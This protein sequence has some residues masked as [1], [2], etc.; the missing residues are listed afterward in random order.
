MVFLP[1]DI[2]A[3]LSQFLYEFLF[4]AAGFHKVCYHKQQIKLPALTFLLCHVLPLSEVHARLGRVVRLEDT[5]PVSQ[6]YFI[7]KLPHIG[8]GVLVHMELVAVLE[9]CGVDNKVVVQLIVVEVS[10]DDD[11]VVREILPD[12]LHPYCVSMLRRELI[13]RAEGLNVLIEQHVVLALGDVLFLLGFVERLRCEEGF[14]SHLRDAV[15]SADEL[16]LLVQICFVRAHTVFQQT[17]LRR[18]CLFALRNIL[19][20]SYFTHPPS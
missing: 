16:D 14:V 10:G 20:Y 3:L 6:T 4:R 11:L 18:G 12:E 13:L 1:P 7:V 8:E 5:Q 19:K 17:V 2:V 15:V 9:A